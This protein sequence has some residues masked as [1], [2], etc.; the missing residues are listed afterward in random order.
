[1]EIPSRTSWLCVGDGGLKKDSSL[2]PPTLTLTS[3]WWRGLASVSYAIL[4]VTFPRDWEGLE[5]VAIV[6]ITTWTLLALDPCYHMKA[7]WF[8][9]LGAVESQKPIRT[10]QTRVVR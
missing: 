4:P 2:C 8:C 5:S 6:K 9:F 3:L 7:C 10:Q 1:M